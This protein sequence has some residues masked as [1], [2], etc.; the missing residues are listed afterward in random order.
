MT[1]FFLPTPGVN[2]ADHNKRILVAPT[3]FRRR[4]PFPTFDD[5]NV[6]ACALRAP[7]QQGGG[8][9]IDKTLRS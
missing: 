7:V 4:N 6:F 2:G 1:Y 9:L 5:G 3:A 8:F